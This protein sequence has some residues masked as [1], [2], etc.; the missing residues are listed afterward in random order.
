[1]NP[2]PITVRCLFIDGIVRPVFFDDAGGQYV[3]DLDGHTRLY[4]V[5][6]APEADVPLLLSIPEPRA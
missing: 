5:W 6:L 3:I 2:D 4:G 1:M